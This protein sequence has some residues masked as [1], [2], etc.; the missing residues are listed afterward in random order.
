[1]F[2]KD[3]YKEASRSI[4]MSSMWWFANFAAAVAAFLA[5]G[6]AYQA[7]IGWILGF[8]ASQY[9]HD[10]VEFVGWL[11]WVVIAGL[12]FFISRASIATLIVTGAFA[13]AV[14]FL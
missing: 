7:T 6:P 2:N 8:S 9:G 1:M 13:V 10:S 3:K 12:L 5:T 11:W 4:F 14:R